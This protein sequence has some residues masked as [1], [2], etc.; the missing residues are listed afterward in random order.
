MIRYIETTAEITGGKTESI[1]DKGNP[2]L[3][4]RAICINKFRQPEKKKRK[5]SPKES[6]RK[7]K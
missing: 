3:Q 1:L 5:Y 7:D 2:Y 6:R 4:A